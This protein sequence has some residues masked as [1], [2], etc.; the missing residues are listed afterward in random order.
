MRVHAAAVNPIDWKVRAGYLKDYIHYSLPVI[1]GWDVS[2]V[3]EATVFGAARFKAG[4]EVYARPDISRNGAYAEYIAVKESELA[5]KPK[6]LDPIHAAAIPLAGLTAWDALFDT[7][8][9]S[10]G[11][12]VLIHGAAG[13]VGSYAVQ[14]TKWKGARRTS[15]A[16]RVT[17]PERSCCALSNC[18]NIAACV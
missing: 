5:H 7:A 1:P 8:R 3:V 6:S 18:G 10:A 13:G 9:L 16:R 15:S 2:G 11:Q 4:D 14:L 12:K 17:P